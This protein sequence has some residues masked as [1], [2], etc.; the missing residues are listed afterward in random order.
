LCGLCFGIGLMILYAICGSRRC[1]AQGIY[2]PVLR[3]LR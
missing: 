1:I 3:N 2:A